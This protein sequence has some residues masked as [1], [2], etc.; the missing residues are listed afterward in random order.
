MTATVDEIDDISIGYLSAANL[1]DGALA[2]Y[3]HAG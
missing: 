1:L 2:V 3:E